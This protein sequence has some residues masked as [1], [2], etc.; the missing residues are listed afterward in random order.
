REQLRLASQQADRLH[1][2]LEALGASELSHGDDTDLPAAWQAAL[3]GLPVVGLAGELAAR[4][5]PIDLLLAGYLRR[6]V[7]LAD[8]ASA[9]EAQRRLAERLPADAPAWAVLSMDGL[10]L[11]AEGARPLEAVRDQGQSVLAD[12][13][14]Q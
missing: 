4:I 8:Q 6:I 1:G 7:V 5:R 9:R 3:Q 10:L 2:A 13:S 12:W 11:A 14:R